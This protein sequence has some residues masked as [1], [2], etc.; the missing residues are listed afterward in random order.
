MALKGNG[1]R[2]PCPP[3]IYISVWQAL[4]LCPGSW[5]NQTEALLLSGSFWSARWFPRSPG[6]LARTQAALWSFGLRGSEV[7]LPEN[8]HPYLASQLM[9]WLSACVQASHT[10]KPRSG[11]INENSPE[12]NGEA[13]LL[14]PFLIIYLSVSSPFADFGGGGGGVLHKDGALP[15]SAQTCPL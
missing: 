8:L 5:R 15:C 7:G 12:S 9:V 1:K 14:Y 10:E 4:T 6:G 13:F 11:E 3:S 2:G